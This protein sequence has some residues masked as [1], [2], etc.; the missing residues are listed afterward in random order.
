MHVSIA[1]KSTTDRRQ[2]PTSTVVPDAATPT[3]TE[4]SIYQSPSTEPNP[5][6]VYDHV[7]KD[8]HRDTSHN[9]VNVAN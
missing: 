3:T 2:S 1:E 4:L 5:T 6:V 8:P 9:Y 7:I